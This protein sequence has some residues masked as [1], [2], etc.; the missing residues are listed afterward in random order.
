MEFYQLVGNAASKLLERSANIQASPAKT[1][2]RVGGPDTEVFFETS[3]QLP[4]I[5]KMN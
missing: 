4:D 1:D 3:W 5:V 2:T